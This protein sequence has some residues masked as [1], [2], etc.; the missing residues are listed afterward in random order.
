M[1]TP[2]GP[3][4]P[5]AQLSPAPALVLGDELDDDPGDDS[6]PMVGPD[7]RA[8]ALTSYASWRWIFLF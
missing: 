8:A 5:A 6:A 7:R 2:V 4:H 3:P 1:M